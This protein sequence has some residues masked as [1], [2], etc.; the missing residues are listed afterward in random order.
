MRSVRRAAVVVV[1][2]TGALALPAAAADV[3]VRVGSYY[4]EDTSAGDGRV[5]VDQG[6]RI[7]FRFEEGQH[8]ATVDGYFDSAVKGEGETYRTPALN[9]AGTFTLYCQVH[10]VPRHGTTLTVRAS[11][12]GPSPTTARPSSSRT[13]APSTAPSPRPT[14]T[15]TA[16]PS[17]RPTPASPRAASGTPAPT[18]PP[19]RSPSPAPAAGEPSSVVPS[20]QALPPAEDGPDAAPSAARDDGAGWLL[21]LGLALI[22]AGLGAAGV[23]VAKRGRT[24]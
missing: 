1:G 16:S 23:A 19:T 10:G 21:P 3:A 11:A 17:P 2:L 5:L 15:R 4:F 6:D 8:T 12:P 18:P 9:R 7:T 22:A 13:A 14:A 24:G 20:A